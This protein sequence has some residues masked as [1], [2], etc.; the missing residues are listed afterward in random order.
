MEFARRIAGV[1][2]VRLPTMCGSGRRQ[3]AVRGNTTAG[4]L[5]EADRLGGP[6]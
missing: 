2:R 3:R 4:A 6:L 1:M 5:W